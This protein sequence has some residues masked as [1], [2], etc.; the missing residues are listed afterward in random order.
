MPRS[1]KP[2][3]K[4]LQRHKNWLEMFKLKAK[5]QREESERL[6][7]EQEEKFHKIKE[8]AAND[9]VKTKKLKEEF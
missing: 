3:N 6:E 8:M 5:L 1:I 7:K 2:V 4:V 9:R